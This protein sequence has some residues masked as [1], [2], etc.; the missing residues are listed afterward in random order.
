MFQ[1][2]NFRLQRTS[3]NHHCLPILLASN[4]FNGYTLRRE[5]TLTDQERHRGELRIRGGRTMF[6][7]IRK[8][9]LWEAWDN[10]LDKEI[11]KAG[12]FHLKTIQDL[13]VYSHL[14]GT[15]GKTIA[16]TGGGA[17]RLLEV[18]ARKNC[19]FNV[20]KFE[21]ADGGPGKEVRIPGVENIKVF[22]GEF[23][24]QLRSEFFDILFS[25]SVVEHVSNLKDFFE[26]GL[27]VLKPGGLWLHAIDIYVEDEPD[28][29]QRSRFEAYRKWFD[30]TALV[31]LG[32]IYRGPLKFTCDIATNPDNIMHAWGRV[33]PQLNALR[34]RA[35]SVSVL[36]GGR[37]A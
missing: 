22:L 21:G 27:R 26:D 20:E 3:S 23:S 9:F 12:A 19:C 36:V 33:A 31:P 1:E 34:Q 5:K 10:G 32:A 8:P 15:T 30:A 17:S 25:V 35:Q 14:R 24:D 13:A 37:K 29:Y 16:E 6:D 7:F 11:G 4:E 18:L 28:E 2:P